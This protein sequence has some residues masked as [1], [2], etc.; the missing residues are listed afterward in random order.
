MYLNCTTEKTVN[1]QKRFEDALLE[2]MKTKEIDKTSVVEICEKAGITRRIFY[3]L[4]ETKYDCLVAAIDH[5]IMA[6]ES[7]VSKG[8]AIDFKRLLEHIKEKDSI[9]NVVEKSRQAGLFMERIFVYS[10]RE[11]EETKRFIRLFGDAGRDIPKEMRK[12]S[13]G[14]LFDLMKRYDLKPEEILVVDDLKPGYD[15]ARGAGVDF[16]AASWAYNVPSIR[17]FMK[18]NCDFFLETIDDLKELIK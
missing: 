17:E 10:L 4:F 3:R 15:M 12:P 7:F 14:T 13:P 18:Q 11:N 5:K 8:G 16:A 9:F 2:I 6:L 1:Q